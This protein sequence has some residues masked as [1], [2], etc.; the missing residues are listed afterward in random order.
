[1]SKYC[2]LGTCGSHHSEV[3]HELPETI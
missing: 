1:M 2:K 3:F